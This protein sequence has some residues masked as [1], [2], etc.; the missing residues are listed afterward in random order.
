MC[1]SRLIR[2]SG[3]VTGSHWVQGGFGKMTTTDGYSS[4]SQVSSRTTGPKP[5]VDRDWFGGYQRRTV[6]AIYRS[7]SRLSF[8]HNPR[9]FKLMTT[10]FAARYRVCN[11]CSSM[12]ILDASNHG[13]FADSGT[14]IIPPSIGSCGLRRAT[15]TKAS[16]PVCQRHVLTINSSY[17]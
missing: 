7:D 17:G 6:T 15:M 14:R 9:T 8:D 1:G 10:P 12:N 4:M 5:S 16:P 3:R 11:W 13:W 2:R